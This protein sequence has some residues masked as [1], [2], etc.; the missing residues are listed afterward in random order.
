[1]LQKFNYF[2]EHEDYTIRLC[3]PNKQQICFLNQ[4]FQQE[5][6]LRFNEM[7]E[8]HITIP[9]KTDGEA[10]PYYDR[11]KSKKLILIDDIGYFLITTVDETDDGIVK[12]KTVTAYSLET[13]LAFKKINIFDGTY[14]F[15]DPI[16]VDN[17]LMGKILSTSNWTIGQIDPDLWN[18]YRTF[19]IPDSTVYEF[20]MN[21]VETSYEC[22]FIFDSFNRTVSAYTLKNLVK[23][24]DIILSYDNLI[25]SID[26][27]EKSD[28]IVT[29]LSVYGGNNL[30]VSA[31]NPLG[32]NTIYDF[33]Y[34]AT[35]EWMS[36]DLIDAINAWEAEVSSKQTSYSNLL[37]QYKDKNTE[38]VTANSALV[39][40]KTDRDAIEG[41]VK[42]MI[43]GDLKNTPEY[44]AKV[45]E[46]NAANAAVA[47]QESHINDLKTQLE[48]INSDLKAINESLAFS[49]FFTEAQYEELKIYMVENTYQ[50]ESFTTTSEMTNS[51]IQ[52]MAQSL[53]NQGKYV[54]E[55]VSQP[56]F[57]FSV[58]SVNFLFLEEFQKFS[59]QLELGC[60][61]NIEKDEAVYV[62]PVLLELNVQLDDPTNFSLVFGNR[63]KLDS[64]EYTFRD[65]F[66]DAIKAGSSVKFDGAKWGEY[67]NSGMN[68]AVSDFINSALDTSKNNVINATNQ[69]ILIN[70]NGLRG[71]TMMDNGTYNPNQVWLT[72]N[73]LAF[74]SDN[75][76]TVRLALGEIDLNGQKIF[77]VAGDALVGKII[78]GNQLII[79]NDNNNFTLDSNGAVLNNASFSIVSNNGLSQIQLNPTQGISIQ[80]R[81]NTSAAWANQFYVDA[82]GNLVI[83][84]KITAN[85]GTIGGW[86]IDSTRLYNS[87]NGDYIGSNGYGKLSL[88]SWTP[89]SAT[90]NGRIYASNLGDQ[91]KTGNIADG[92]VTSA[93]LDTLYATKAFVDEMN[94]ELANV[95]TLAANAATIQQLNA[96][97]ATIAN[98]D[99]TNL[100]FQERSASWTQTPIVYDLNV[101]NTLVITSVD[102]DN[103]T[104]TAANIT[105]IRNFYKTSGMWVVAG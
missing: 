29:A 102:F 75:W 18:V 51:E 82:Q 28:E 24:T 9:Y 87:D 78:A 95:H 31:V 36:Q 88:L 5:L 79:S 8:F 41:V 37:T 71:R 80:T 14:K 92:S 60:V 40:L 13:E 66:G 84:G 91:I 63:Y 49:K 72:S 62:K 7:S 55:R 16:N 90:F 73:T 57:E 32:T 21:D 104:Y 96:T 97:N 56:R 61:I 68:N 58:E 30:G 48:V 44:T 81:A 76:Q 98:L 94:V 50:N 69:E 85:S 27:N 23:N 45:N 70:Q 1:M 2:G 39:D 46:L 10:F 67:V 59:Q 22:V 54:L 42:V 101:T 33:S 86:Q 15:Y 53:Y 100:K 83:N 64:G 65:L 35:T 3:N 99:L 17:T 12:Q 38:I 4:G 93:K 26:I 103:K 77:G 20:L 52:D 105:G 25:Q 11:I 43:E 19:E 6:S 34:F 74:T 89:T 47:A